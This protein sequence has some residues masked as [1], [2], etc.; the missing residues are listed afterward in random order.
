MRVNDADHLAQV[1]RRG[2]ILWIQP[3]LFVGISGDVPAREV[4]LCTA[5]CQ[6]QA[7]ALTWISA[8]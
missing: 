3:E 5:D 7:A 1:F 4:L 2:V 8:R 6:Q